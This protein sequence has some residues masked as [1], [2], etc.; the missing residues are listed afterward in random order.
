MEVR[1]DAL[2]GSFACNVL[3]D[4]VHRALI[5]RYTHILYHYVGIL[6][7]LMYIPGKFFNAVRYVPYLVVGLTL[8]GFMQQY[9][10]NN[11]IPQLH[12]YLVTVVY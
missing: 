7:R 3:Y 9:S 12:F 8:F 6:L 1:S 5:N 11:S 10:N 4:T 2:Y